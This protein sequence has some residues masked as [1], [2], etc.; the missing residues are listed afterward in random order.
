MLIQIFARAN[1]LSWKLLDGSPPKLI[2]SRL[3]RTINPVLSLSVF[4]GNNVLHEPMHCY[5]GNALMDAHHGLRTFI[6][7]IS[8]VFK[9]V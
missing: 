9:S 8:V 7:K 3:E 5:H 4:P 6:R 2:L 1:G